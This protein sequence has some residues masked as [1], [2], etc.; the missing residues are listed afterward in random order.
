MAAWRC[1]E[2][3]RLGLRWPLSRKRKR[4]VGRPSNQDLFHAEISKALWSGSLPD[5]L[6]SADLPSWWHPGQPLVQTA[7]MLALTTQNTDVSFPMEPSERVIDAAPQQGETQEGKQTPNAPSEKVS[8]ATPLD[9]ESQAGEAAPTTPIAKHVS[10]TSPISGQKPRKPRKA[11][12]PPEAK[13]WFIEY[14]LFQ[15]D[16]YEWSLLQSWRAAQ[17]LAPNL[18]AHVHRDTIYRWKTPSRKTPGQLEMRGVKSTLPLVALTRLN[19]IAC[20]LSKV[21][22]L[23]SELGVHIFKEQLR[24]MGIEYQSGLAMNT[25]RA[26]RCSCSVFGVRDI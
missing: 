26:V 14:Q 6:T 17:R 16:R 19:E 25:V 21:V 3:E 11:F 12:V 22:P 7:E 23:S 13:T 2:A 18:F 5:G 15:K 9:G 10:S 1:A 20:A 4:H 8:D 24:V